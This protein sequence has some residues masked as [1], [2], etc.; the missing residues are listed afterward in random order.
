MADDTGFR[1][2]IKTG[3]VDKVKTFLDK[4]P[5]K[6]TTCCYDIVGAIGY[7]ISCGTKCHPV[8]KTLFNKF[9]SQKFPVGSTETGKTTKIPLSEHHS[10]MQEWTCKMTASEE[11]VD[12]DMFKY[13]L[14]KYCGDN[15]GEILCTAASAGNA[16]ALASCFNRNNA[17]R[18]S[19]TDR[20]NALICAAQCN[21]IS[22]AKILMKF[23]ANPCVPNSDGMTAFQACRDNTS[24]EMAK[25]LSKCLPKATRTA[26]VPAGISKTATKGKKARSKA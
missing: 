17:E 2:A 16:K 8:T 4:N 19:Q 6:V 14:G 22:C 21:S 24:P 15:I 25:C 20:D 1:K 10:I 9:K 23:D 7:S 3:D 13:F 11:K 12:V 18:F 5:Y 26:T